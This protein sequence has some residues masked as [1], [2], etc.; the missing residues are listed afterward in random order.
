M[1]TK[2]QKKQELEEYQAEE[3]FHRREWRVQRIGWALLGGLIIAAL[4]GL[5]GNGP[6][7]RQTLVLGDST[8]EID[9]FMRRE[10]RSEWIIRT[11]RS[12]AESN[13]QVR[14]SADLL[15]H[16]RIASIV[17]EPREQKLETDAIVFTFD[18]AGLGPEIVFHIEAFE[19]GATRGEIQIGNAAMPVKLWIYP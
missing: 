1:A 9:R 7:S 6:L 4:L 5:L 12:P 11:P 15:R 18:A 17:P 2:K 13:Y 19:F 8:V 14:L 3:T 16:I 10:A